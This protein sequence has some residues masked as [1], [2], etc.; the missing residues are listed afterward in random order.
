MVTRLTENVRDRVAYHSPSLP[1]ITCA[2]SMAYHNLHMLGCQESHG[3][4]GWLTN[5]NLDDVDVSSIPPDHRVAF[6]SC[7]GRSFRL[8]NVSGKW[9]MVTILSNVHSDGLFIDNQ[10]L[11]VEETKAL[12]KS[13]EADGYRIT[14]MIGDGV[15]LDIKTLTEYSGN[16]QCSDVRISGDTADSYRDELRT[17]AGNKQWRIDSD[18]DSNFEMRREIRNLFD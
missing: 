15:N 7:V 13:M 14:L 9:Q 10:T 3:H 6:M 4:T 1:E 11:D 18:T 17:W 16:G 2:A 5:T 12:V 8:N